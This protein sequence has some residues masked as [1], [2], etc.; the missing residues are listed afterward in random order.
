[1][2]GGGTSRLGEQSTA[3]GGHLI[4]GE[5]LDGGTS[6]LD[7]QCMA[8]SGHLVNGETWGGGIS[9]WL[10]EQSAAIGGPMRCQQHIPGVRRAL[11]GLTPWR[12]IGKGVLQ[13]ALGRTA[14]IPVCEGRRVRG[15]HCC[16][17][18][19]S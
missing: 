6:W 17:Q 10:G 7:D 1:M 5:M 14:V 18:S 19:P 9:L 3:T 15:A 13:S 11:R 16:A 12:R 8:T 2:L 4:N